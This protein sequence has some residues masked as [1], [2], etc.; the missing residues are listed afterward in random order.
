MIQT[1]EAF[2][3]GD[4]FGKVTE[5]VT[6]KEIRNSFRV[7]DRILTPEQSLTHK[8]LFYGQVTDDTEQTLY[9][10]DA[11]VQKKEMTS[12]ISASALLKWMLET[13]SDCYIGPSSKKALIDIEKGLDVN[14]AG[15]T[16]ITCGGVM[17]SLAALLISRNHTELVSNTKSVLIP[18]H[19]TS[20]AM[21][22]AGCFVFAMEAAAMHKDIDEIIDSSV[23]G[24]EE[25]SEFGDKFRQNGC[26]P[27]CGSRI[28][29]IKDLM[30][31]ISSESSFASFLYYNFGTTMS[32]IDV[33]TSAL[34]IF[35]WFKGDVFKAIKFSTELGGDTDTIACLTAALSTLYA[36]GHNIPREIVNLVSV[37]NKINFEN[38][39]D[40]LCGVLKE[41]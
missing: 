38:I 33:C 22:S 26:G 6:Q 35:L 34:A 17:R 2:A 19:N 21:E 15:I 39:V 18:T 7:I 41:K 37:S 36:G 11:F 4:A 5:Y 31:E 14:K 23:K 25:F 9:L 10:I 12:E 24:A 3:V 27:S 40:K 8:D 16:G 20:L 13:N 28:L 29:L 30:K 1:L 32:S